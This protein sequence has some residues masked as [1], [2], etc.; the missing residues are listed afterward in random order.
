MSIVRRASGGRQHVLATADVSGGQGRTGQRGSL[1]SKAEGRR[2]VMSATEDRYND[3]S[4]RAAAE[5]VDDEVDGRVGDD[6]QVTET[7]VEEERTRAGLGV[8]AEKNDQ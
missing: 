7:H 3:L 6:Q 4:K 1:R 5:A 8:V 2:G